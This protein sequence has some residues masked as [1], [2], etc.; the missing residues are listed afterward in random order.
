MKSPTVLLW[1]LIDDVKRHHPSVRGL[2][3]DKN[4]IR[5]RVKHEGIGFL[6][7]AF[8]DLRSALDEGLS[9]GTFT[10][11]RNFKRVPR[12]AIPRIFSGMFCKVFDSSTGHLLNDADPLVVKS[13]R[14]VLCLFRK[15]Q[16]SAEADA[17]LDH[18]AIRGFF[19][20][21][22]EI[23]S[24]ESD[25]LTHRM[26]LL[27]RLV[28][29]DLHNFDPVELEPKHGPGAVF[30]GYT[31]NQ[32]WDGA[33]SSTD[34]LIN[35]GFDAFALS[36][37]LGSI[38]SKEDELFFKTPARSIA[39]LCTVPKDFHSRR[40]ITIEPAEQQFIQ[41]GLNKVLRDS[42]E[43]C[44][45]LTQC[46]AL[47]DQTKNQY[48][49][50]V[51][52]Q[53]DEWATIDLS[54]ASDRLSN[55]LVQ[56][57]FESKSLFLEA[58]LDSRS[59]Y[60]TSPLMEGA[61][62]KFAGMGN[63]TTFPVQSVVFAL[64]AISA[65]LGNKRVTYRSVKRAASYVR[66]YGD[67][68]I[69]KREHAQAVVSEL[70]LA[71]LVV[72][73]SKSF[74]S[75]N[76]KES[77]GVDAFRGVDVTPLY[78]RYLS[79]KHLQRQAQELAHLVQLS[80]HMWLRGLYKAATCIKED[81]E[82]RYGTLPIGPS[83]AGYLCWHTRHD[84]YVPQRWDT[85]LHRWL[86]KAPVVRSPIVR[87]PIKNGYAALL[88]FYLTSFIGRRAGHLDRSAVRHRLSVQRRWVPV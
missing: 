74:L 31:P 30:E 68:I 33:L 12:G 65:C 50:I 26:E 87:D 14:E 75:G 62:R 71:G 41:Q 73:K 9:T 88:K 72:N 18:Q 52:S 11:P 83:D 42:I 51:G 46:L 28:L 66:V 16:G 44:P 58:L 35:Y 80:N 39:R 2:D 24:L 6:T 77:C 19:Q 29:Q 38:G 76:F 36:M 49:A 54:K 56:I 86:V 60:V 79:D 5:Y 40:T 27:G 84:A 7:V 17:I 57:T 59:A 15:L 32:K 25:R 48:L 70:E 78:V 20:C 67:D 47:S 22:D 34:R 82:A 4:S 23:R 45:I 10:C 53:T 64:L 21:D 8:G 13:L 81:V 61:L 43:K 69:V 85:K 55:E 3:R 37:G 1:C 63:A